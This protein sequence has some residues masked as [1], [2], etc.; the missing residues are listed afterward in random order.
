M[1][2][3]RV[4][5]FTFQTIVRFISVWPFLISRTY[6][7]NRTILETGAREPRI[8]LPIAYTLYFVLSWRMDYVDV[9]KSEAAMELME[10]GLRLST[11]TFMNAPFV[12]IA[13]NQSF[14]L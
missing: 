10:E 11:N 12:L 2:C 3:L 6:P 5:I 14:L 7:T 1:H 13:S 4:L 9:G 8:I